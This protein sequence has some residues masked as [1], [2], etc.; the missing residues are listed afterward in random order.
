MGGRRA[1]AQRPLRT[2]RA[3]LPQ[4]GDVPGSAGAYVC[5]CAGVGETSCVSDASAVQQRLTGAPAQFL[6]HLLIWQLM[7]EE[8]LR[9][10]NDF[11]GAQILVVS[12]RTCVILPL[13][14]REWESHVSSLVERVLGWRDPHEAS[15]Q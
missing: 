13:S 10:C 1:P 12:W 6:V 14:R 8:V 5:G 7:Y 2:R 3:D 11:T 4:S 15:L 9:I